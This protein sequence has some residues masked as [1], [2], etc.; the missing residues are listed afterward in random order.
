MIAQK[1][2]LQ[3]I[4]S[5]GLAVN[6]GVKSYIASTTDDRCGDAGPSSANVLQ[7]EIEPEMAIPKLKG[8]KATEIAVEKIEAKLTNVCQN[9]MTYPFVSLKNLPYMTNCSVTYD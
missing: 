7:D 6:S 9:I 5:A 4:P 8:A 2:K 1:Q 3:E